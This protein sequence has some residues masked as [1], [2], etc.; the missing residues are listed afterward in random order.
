MAHLFGSMSPHRG[1][2]T[3]FP[4]WLYVSVSSDGVEVAGASARREY[5]RRRTRD[6]DAI[7]DAWGS[8]GEV[9][10]ALTPERQSTTAW[11]R[12][13]G[14]EE[15]VGAALERVKSYPV[16]VL[17]DRRLPGSRANIDHLVVTSSAVWVID[18]KR[19]RGRPALRVEGGI[20]RPRTE[21]LTVDGRDQSRL[22]AG[23]AGQVQRV[24]D[25]VPDVPVKGVLCFV[26][27][28]WPL[29]G[30]AFFIEGV[31]VCWPRRL[32][33][34]LRPVGPY[35]VDLDAVTSVLSSRFRPA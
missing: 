15:Q 1:I 33:D 9:A 34:T 24:R 6:R 3:A 23:I 35:V 5:E 16:R 29:I 4:W 32:A 21:T 31:H 18:A 22:V 26:N 2:D 13:A 14:G 19:Y 27:A 28:D 7:R 11:S 20:F 17:H 25:V 8:F 12:G 30:G 10:V